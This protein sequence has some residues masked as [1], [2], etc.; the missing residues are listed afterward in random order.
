MSRSAGTE[1]PI[2]HLGPKKH[3]S[4][5][6]TLY[7]V[8]F[9]LRSAAAPKQAGPN[10]YLKGVGADYD[11]EW[12]RKLPAR[13]ARMTL[14]SLIW[15]PLVQFYCHPTIRGTDRLDRIDGPV[16]F[17]S[18]HFSHAD[19]PLLM[20]SVPSPRRHKLMFA[21]AADYFFPTRAKGALASIVVGA[22]PIERAKLSKSAVAE[23]IRLLK[24]GWNIVIYPEGGRSPDGWGQ[25][26]RPGAAFI[27]RLAEVPV[28]PV[29]IKGTRDVLTRGTNFPTRA[30]V[31]IVFGQPLYHVEGESN[32]AFTDR[33]EHSVAALADE[34]IADWW[35]SRK[36][37]YG[38]SSSD[39]AGPEQAG[40]RRKWALSKSE[41]KSD[42]VW[43][44]L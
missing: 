36:R 21:A 10:P 31:T 24:N 1:R 35:T 8:P 33:I 28:V 26:F 37:Y 29:Y 38:G 3:F 13:F 17:A 43:P 23:P 18:N 2:R 41:Q 6:R 22:I 5:L 12:S 16:V 40:W 4:L 7:Q 11:T 14:T 44:K 20:T 27:A 9:P 34:A 15:Q 30:Q 32:Q 25:S 42:R 39:L 19:T